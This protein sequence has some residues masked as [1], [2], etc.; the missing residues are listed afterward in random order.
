MQWQWSSLSS[1]AME[2]QPQTLCAKA[3]RVARGSRRGRKEMTRPFQVERAICACC[4]L[5]G[6]TTEHSSDA[7]GCY[8][9]GRRLG[10]DNSRSFLG[11][12][13]TTPSVPCRQN[14]LFFQQVLSGP[15]VLATQSCRCWGHSCGQ[16]DKNPCLQG[17]D[18][19]VQRLACFLQMF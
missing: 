7:S 9:Q 2:F 12:D 8:H 1:G 18:L 3:L 11:H 5:V 19:P 10:L 13:L 4:V 14:D 16:T 17:A 6:D 15:L